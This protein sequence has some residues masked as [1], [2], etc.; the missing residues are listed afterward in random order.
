MH[1][2]AHSQTFQVLTRTNKCITNKCVQTFEQ[3]E[4]DQPHIQY[5]DGKE[6]VIGILGLE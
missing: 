3:I 5:I 6:P 4:A 1:T 2:A